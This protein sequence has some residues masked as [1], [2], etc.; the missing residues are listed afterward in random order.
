MSQPKMGRWPGMS[1]GSEAGAGD[2]TTGVGPGTHLRTH[3][4]RPAA[5]GDPG[6]F[7]RR[8]LLTLAGGHCL[9][10]MT[11]G[12]LPALLPLFTA[13][14]ALSDFQASMILG[15]STF[16]SSAV[17]PIFGWIADRR[18]A[19]WL[20]WGGVAVAALFFALAGFASS[21]LLV[22]ACI[23]GSGLGVAAYHPEA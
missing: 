7:D 14:F 10:D 17:Q 6:A 1:V 22:L 16:A 15:A 11:V 19:A 3:P 21:Y 5:A 12:G 13:A 4:P 9:V 8:G 18:P 20:L 2:R 23:V